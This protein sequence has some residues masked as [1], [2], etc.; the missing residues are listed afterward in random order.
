MLLCVCVYFSIRSGIWSIK[1]RRRQRR[2]RRRRWSR[3]AL[4]SIERS[5]RAERLAHVS[6]TA[7][8]LCLL[9]V[10][11]W[12][13]S[14]ASTHT[15]HS[16]HTH[17]NRPLNHVRVRFRLCG[18][19]RAHSMPIV[20]WLHLPKQRPR[21]SISRHFWQLTARARPTIQPPIDIRAHAQVDFWPYFSSI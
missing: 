13:R 8:A 21:P 9:S 6:T 19:A 7:N 2:R 14:M 10:V 1:T 11:S 4:K 20:E 15:Q 16:Q 17:K 12:L 5:R 3:R 18:R